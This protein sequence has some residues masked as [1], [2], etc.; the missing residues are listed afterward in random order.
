MTISSPSKAAVE[1]RKAEIAEKFKAATEQLSPPSAARDFSLADVQLTMQN[2]RL[3]INGELVA[4]GEDGA[5]SRFSGGL[6]Y[7]YLRG[8]GRFDFSIRPDAG[9]GFQ[10]LGVI[11][12][13]KISFSIGS[14]TYEWI[15]SA[16]IVGAGGTWNLYVWH[17]PDYELDSRYRNSRILI[18]ASGGIQI[19]NP[20]KDA[21][22]RK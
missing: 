2:Y 4:G 17:R 19:W 9:P 21:P 8:R 10:K 5:V 11:Q 16:P 12:N 7:F 6:I 18:G 15:S 22:T 3:L 13:N 14:D 20:P 1:R